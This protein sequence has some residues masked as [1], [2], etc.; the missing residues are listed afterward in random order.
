[1][2]MQSVR[3]VTIVTAAALGSL[4]ASSAIAAKSA[5][6]VQ[7]QGAV[8]ARVMQIGDIGQSTSINE[9]IRQKV[10]LLQAAQTIIPTD[11]AAYAQP[12]VDVKRIVDLQVSRGTPWISSL[13]KLLNANGLFSVVDWDARSVYLR[14]SPAD[15]SSL[16]RIMGA[17][18]VA[19]QATSQQRPGPANYP[20]M[21]AGARQTMVV[22][23][24]TG[25][26]SQFP[27]AQAAGG[28]VPQQPY[29]FSVQRTDRT[30][31]DVVQRWAM[32]SGWA[33]ES[34]YWAAP[35]DLPVVGASSFTG[36]FEEAVI[37]L[38]GTTR[39]SDMPVKPCFYTNR[40]VRVQLATTRCDWGT[41]D[42]AE[43]Q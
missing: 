37:S 42:K 31:R 2:S 38:L 23:P 36:T 6:A 40:V 43:N 17:N 33:F 20:N 15:A 22:N 9:S 13:D 11:W 30:V 7:A 26:Y 25:A 1:M 41:E 3:V 27:A 29:T 32:Q 10:S 24:Q 16:N 8:S 18:S 35:K 39:L 12:G 34:T 19:Q 21:A 4:V 28:F 14:S 5:P